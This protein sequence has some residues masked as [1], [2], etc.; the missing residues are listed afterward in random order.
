MPIMQWLYFDALECLAEEEGITLTEEECA[1]VGV[2]SRT[3]TLIAK[4]NVHDKCTGLNMFYACYDF[5]FR[6]TVDMTGRLQCLAPRCRI[7]LPSSA[8]SW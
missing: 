4:Y 6:E 1:P 5:P 3:D 2:H 8:T 7:S